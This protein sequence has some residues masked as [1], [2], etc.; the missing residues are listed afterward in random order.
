[1][2]ARIGRMDPNDELLSGQQNK[3]LEI[4]KWKRC[5]TD[6]RTLDVIMMKCDEM[7]EDSELRHLHGD[8]LGVRIYGRMSTGKL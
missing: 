8:E 1:M 2:V 3:L 4:S 7:Y 6:V 5:I